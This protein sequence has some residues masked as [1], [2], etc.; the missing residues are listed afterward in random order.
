MAKVYG[1]FFGGHGYSTSLIVDGEI[2]YAVEDERITRRKAGYSWFEAPIHSLDAIEKASGI[3]LEDADKIVICDA[4]LLFIVQRDNM[5]FEQPDN[6]MVKFR[7]RL[8]NLKDKIEWVGHHE[9]HAYS[10]YYVS[11]FTDKTLVLT[12]DG[13]SFEK[14]YGSIWLAENGKMNQVHRQYNSLQPSH[15]D[16]VHSALRN[17]FPPSLVLPLRYGKPL[18][19]YWLGLLDTPTIVYP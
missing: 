17:V 18:T 2:K 5:E 7:Q 15:S 13:G 12:S 16:K 19:Y 11:G 1:L 10:T 3:K 9:S 14:D 8:I 6:D 4:T